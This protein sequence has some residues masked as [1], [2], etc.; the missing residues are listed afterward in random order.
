MLLKSNLDSYYIQSR[1]ARKKSGSTA[2]GVQESVQQYAVPH[3]REDQ[4][5]LTFNLFR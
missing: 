1:C 3:D 4:L 2:A 5:L